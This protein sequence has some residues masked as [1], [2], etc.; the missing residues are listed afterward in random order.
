MVLK[1]GAIGK[2]P[3]PEIRKFL[4]SLHTVSWEGTSVS[5]SGLERLVRHAVVASSLFFLNLGDDKVNCLAS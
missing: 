2:L 1:F 3:I 4:R 5:G